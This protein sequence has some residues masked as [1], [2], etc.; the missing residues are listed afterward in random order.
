MSSWRYWVLLSLKR[1]LEE[2]E[3]V[4]VFS[5]SNRREIRP[6]PW[7]W[8]KRT[9][10]NT[11]KSREGLC[12]PN[13]RNNLEK[14]NTEPSALWLL[15]RLVCSREA[16]R[17][18]LDPHLWRR[19]KEISRLDG[20]LHEFWKGF[21]MEILWFLK[22]KTS[23]GQTKVFCSFVWSRVNNI[24]SPPLPGAMDRKPFSNEE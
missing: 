15:W 18:S 9:R 2:E 16:L 20:H 21:Q 8:K 6:A 13:R 11:R 22:M 23:N 3:R 12:Q 19:F 17:R 14:S 1:R 7:I 24:P 5:Y 10:A 4:T